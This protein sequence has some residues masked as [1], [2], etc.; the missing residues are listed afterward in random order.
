MLWIGSWWYGGVLGRAG[1][2]FGWEVRMEPN[3]LVLYCHRTDPLDQRGWMS[4]VWSI[5]ENYSFGWQ[6]LSKRARRG[7]HWWNWLGFA[8]FIGGTRSGL[9]VHAWSIPDWLTAAV[10]IIAPARKVF[11]KRRR[12]KRLLRGVCPM[13]GYDLR[14]TPARCP[15]CGWLSDTNPRKNS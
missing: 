6:P 4:G 15:E 1:S 11:V 2:R 13:C 10:P 8:H 14:A 5:P 12:R 9:P 7:A 3:V